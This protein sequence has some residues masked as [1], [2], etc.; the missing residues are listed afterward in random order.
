MNFNHE[1]VS[2]HLGALDLDL[3]LLKDRPANFTAPSTEAQKSNHKAWV[4]SNRL[5]LNFIRM[6]ISNNIKST[7]PSIENRHAKDF[8]KLVEEKFRS[9][10]KALAGTLM[11]KLT[12]MKF[13]GSK[14]PLEYGPFHINY[15]TLKDKWNIDELSRVDKKLKPKAKNFKKKQDGITSKVANA[16]KKEQ[17]G[18]KYFHIAIDNDL[19][20]FS[21]AI[22]SDKSEMWIDA[23]KEVL[24]SMA[25]NKVWDLVNLPESSKRVGCKWVFK[26]KRDSKGNV[27]RHKAR[28]VAKGYTQKNGADYNETFSPVSNKDS[29]KLILALVAYFDLELH[30]MDYV[31]L[32]LLEADGDDDDDADDDYAPAASEGEGDGD[33]DD[34]D[35][36]KITLQQHE[37][38]M[39][40]YNTDTITSGNIQDEKP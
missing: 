36:I 11:A 9:A 25:Q 16:K 19:V 29:L 27:E 22:K 18:N 39:K 4:R 37:Y 12:I 3:A 2:F 20:S 7:L 6:T 24:K 40:S 31:P 32:A 1:Q 35:V 34:D 38:N 14:I 17:L 33:D 26:T 23:M 10:D 21:H 28:L 13:D 15:S 5:C 30:Q 8:L